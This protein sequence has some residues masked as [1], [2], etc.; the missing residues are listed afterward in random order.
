MASAF[1]AS[2]GTVIAGAV[3]WG[4]TSQKNSREEKWDP[5]K[6]VIDPTLVQRGENE[7]FSAVPAVLLNKKEEKVITPTT[8]SAVVLE[9]PDETPKL[10]DAGMSV[11][12]TLRTKFGGVQINK[13]TNVSFNTLQME[14][15]DQSRLNEFALQELKEMEFIVGIDKTFKCPFENMIQVLHQQPSVMI[16]ATSPQMERV[17]QEKIHQG[18]SK[19]I[20]P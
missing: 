8:K 3:A 17:M 19:E 1:V 2:I 13:P 4:W 5:N 10:S 18:Q 20:K 9:K 7:A 14:E 11:L 16:G 15:P 6:Y 12:S